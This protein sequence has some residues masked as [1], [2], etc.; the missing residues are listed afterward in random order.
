[1]SA[2]TIRMGMCGSML[3]RHHAR[4]PLP[5]AGVLDLT[6]GFTDYRLRRVLAPNSPLRSAVT[7]QAPESGESE[8]ASL[9]HEGL[10]EDD[11]VRHRPLPCT[12]SLGRASGPFWTSDINSQLVTLMP[13]AYQRRRIV[14]YF[15]RQRLPSIPLRQHCLH[16]DNYHV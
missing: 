5:S 9:Q 10:A 6:F 14:W 1:M 16:H 3:Q 13:S 15:W 2:P 4:S 11:S 12:I 7:A 8:N